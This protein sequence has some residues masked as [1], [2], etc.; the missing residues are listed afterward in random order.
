[1]LPNYGALITYNP[2]IILPS[3]LNP[4]LVKKVQVSNMA[5]TWFPYHWLRHT[6]LSSIQ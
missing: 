1:M 3:V 4:A 6:L 2:V 5:W